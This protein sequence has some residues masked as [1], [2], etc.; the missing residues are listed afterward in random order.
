MGIDK[1]RQDYDRNQGRREIK[2]MIPLSW[3][4]RKLKEMKV[5]IHGAFTKSK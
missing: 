1:D 3:I 2:I 4:Y 5:K